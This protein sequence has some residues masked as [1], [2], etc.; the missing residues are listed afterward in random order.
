MANRKQ[1]RIAGCFF[2]SVSKKIKIND[3]NPKV[4]KGED[5]NNNN[6]ETSHFNKDH[7]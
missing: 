7:T 1:K 6:A 2:P 4:I 5:E 3:T